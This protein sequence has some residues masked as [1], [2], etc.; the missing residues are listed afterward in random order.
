MVDSLT[1]QII[2]TVLAGLAYAVGLTGII[3]PVLPG[4][5]TIVIATLVWAILIG[6]WPAWL[7]APLGASAV[8]VFAVPAEVLLTT[9]R[10]AVAAIA[11]H[12]VAVPT[13]AVAAIIV[14]RAG[15]NQ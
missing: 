5:I 9:R 8:L 15:F 13:G 14:E 2:V 12:A 11:S 7:V 10:F 1:V 4:T 6:G 3:V